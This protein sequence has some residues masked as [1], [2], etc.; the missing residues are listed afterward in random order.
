[1]LTSPDGVR[2]PTAQPEQV[3]CIGRIERG[4]PWAKERALTYLMA[5]HRPDFETSGVILFA[6]T[7]SSNP[8]ALVNLFGAEMPGKNLVLSPQKPSAPEKPASHWEKRV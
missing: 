3:F 7:K 1:M 8:V 4:A 5:A 2:C 6:R